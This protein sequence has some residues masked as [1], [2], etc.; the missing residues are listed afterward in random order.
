[1]NDT[2]LERVAGLVSD[3]QR[4]EHHS[5]IELLADF[6]WKEYAEFA[7]EFITAD[8][9]VT[10]VCVRLEVAVRAARMGD[11]GSAIE[12]LRLASDEIQVVINR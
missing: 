7:D 8:S 12:S 1:M 2:R 11:W 9:Q 4:T 10:V 5:S 6:A 3:A